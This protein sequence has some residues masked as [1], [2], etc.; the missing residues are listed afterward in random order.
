[1]LRKVLFFVVVLVL[2]VNFCCCASATTTTDEGYTQITQQYYSD[3][4]QHLEKKMYKD[5][6][7]LYELKS[8]C[9]N[10]IFD[11]M[12]IPVDE[13]FICISGM[14]DIAYFFKN[15][16]GNYY[17]FK[18]KTYDSKGIIQYL[19]EKEDWDPVCWY[20][21]GKIFVSFIEE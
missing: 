9:K 8:A 2:S 16:E 4:Y 7:N 19:I 11:E 5:N 3:T 14:E 17:M 6:S 10:A 20:G 21:D 18:V 1:M 13:D 15:T 12:E